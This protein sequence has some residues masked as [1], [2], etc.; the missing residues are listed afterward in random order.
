M[1]CHRN[2]TGVQNGL[3]KHV[4]LVHSIITV[5]SRTTTFIP[6]GKKCVRAELLPAYGSP[7]PLRNSLEHPLCNTRPHA[8]RALRHYGSKDKT[9]KWRR[10][11]HETRA[12][13][14]MGGAQGR[15]RT[16]LESISKKKERRAWEDF[17]GGLQLAAKNRRW[18]YYL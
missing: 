4:Y 1:I 9:H 15:G 11:K 14:V 2:G 3:R 8:P 16:F 18:I 10:T 7:V 5:V 6:P 13:E 12:R 17:F